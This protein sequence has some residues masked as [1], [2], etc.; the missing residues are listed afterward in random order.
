MRASRAVVAIWSLVIVGL[1]A[2][3]I[4]ELTH[5]FSLSIGSALLDPTALL[6][7]LVFTTIIAVVGAIFVGISITAR[8]LQPRGFTPFEEEML[9]MR[10]DVAELRRRAEERGP[11]AAPSPNPAPRSEAPPRPP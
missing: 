7:G 11:H 9:K 8:Y 1:V 5:F 10:A 3:E 6:V 2:L 4:A